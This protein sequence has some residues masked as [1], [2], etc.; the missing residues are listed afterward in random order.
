[1]AR[2]KLTPQQI[3]GLRRSIQ[4]ALD[5]FIEQSPEWLREQGLVELKFVREAFANEQ[6]FGEKGLPKPLGA[7]GDAWRRK[8]L[9]EGWSLKKGHAKPGGLSSAVGDPST[10]RKTETGYRI[11]IGNKRGPWRNYWQDYRR[12]KAP[13]LMRFKVGWE[14]RHRKHIRSRGGKLVKRMVGNVATLDGQKGVVRILAKLDIPLSG[15]KRQ[16]AAAPFR[17]PRKI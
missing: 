14:L 1:M 4:S 11:N 8:K 7:Y 17:P 13:T 15:A 9:A 16:G 10:M 6:Y 5:Q 12:E 3:G 2:R